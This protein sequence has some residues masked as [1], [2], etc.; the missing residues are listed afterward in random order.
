MQALGF[1]RLH[2][3][4]G[5]MSSAQTTTSPT[6]GSVP[7]HWT[8]PMLVTIS[9]IPSVAHPTI[10]PGAHPQRTAKFSNFQNTRAGKAIV[11]P[12]PSS[13]KSK[14]TIRIA[15][16]KS[17]ASPSSTSHATFSA[18][19]WPTSHDGTDKLAA[20]QN[21]DQRCA[22]QGGSCRAGHRAPP[23]ATEI[24]ANQRH[25][26]LSWFACKPLPGNGTFQRVH[27]R[28]AENQPLR[29]GNRLKVI[30]WFWL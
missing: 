16:P 10:S 17:G 3:N 27:Q 23:H 5:M 15:L 8:N 13:W 14:R 2:R 18:R 12:K 26:P 20:C 19:R 22:L 9:M 24:T 7:P 4:N 29:Q 6:S 25:G 1:G 21:H 28:R 30:E 11:S